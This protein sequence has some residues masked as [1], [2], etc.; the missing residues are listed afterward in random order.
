VARRETR[1][2]LIGVF[3]SAPG[4]GNLRTPRTSAL[5]R[6]FASRLEVNAFERVKFIVMFLDFAQFQIC[7]WDSSHVRV[8]RRQNKNAISSPANLNRKSLSSRR[9]GVIPVEPGNKCGADLSRTHRFALVMVSAI[10]KSALVHFPDHP[11]NS[12]VPFCLALWQKPKVR[13]LSCDKKHRRRVWASRHTSAAADA[14]GCFHRK[15]C[16]RL[17]YRRRIGVRCRPG[18]RRDISTRFDNA[19]KSVTI[20]SKILAQRKCRGSERFDPD[21]LSASEAAHIKLAGSLCRAQSMGN[22]VDH[23]GTHSANAFS[24]VGVER[25][26]LFVTKDQS[27]IHD[28][29]HLQKGG[30][31]RNLNPPCSRRTSPRFASLSGASDNFCRIN[32]SLSGNAMRTAGRVLETKAFNIVTKLS[33]RCSCGSSSKAASNNNDVKPPLVIG[34]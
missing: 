22:T 34:N 15:I 27:F 18:S 4:S 16:V 33:E 3:G 25:Y 6:S 8:F 21:R 20:H 9:G 5:T 17:W 24:A 30:F 1:A 12:P 11:E 7:H 2:Q 14:G 26:W 13:N 29:E 23:E 28:I 19:I 10:S 31:S 32:A